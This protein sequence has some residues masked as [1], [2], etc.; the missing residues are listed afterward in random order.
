MTI[1][2]GLVALIVGAAFLVLLV[3]VDGSVASTERARRADNALVEANRVERLVIDLETG[4][5]GFVLTGDERFLEPWR[6]AQELLP[7]VTA[8]LER[9]TVDSPGEAGALQLTEDVTSY[10]EDYSIPLVEAA[11]RHEPTAASVAATLEGKRRVD[12]LRGAVDRLLATEQADLETN[13]GHTDASIRRAIAIAAGGL[14]GSILLIVFFGIYLTRAIVAPIRRAAVMA[15]R[16]AG[17]DLGS[18]MMA[19]GPAEIG[20]LESSFNVMADSLQRDRDELS[21]LAEEQAA[22]RRVA[23]LVASAAPAAELFAAVSEEVGRLLPVDITH[24]TRYGSDG[25]AT[26]VAGWDRSG[27]QVP[28]GARHPL[29]G[30]NLSTIILE[31]RSPARIDVGA[32]SGAMAAAAKAVGARSG[33]GT[34]IVVAGRLWGV[35][36]AASTSEEPLPED[37]EAR[38][39]GFTDLVATAIANAESRTELAASRARVVEAADASRRRIERDL[40]DGA[41]QRLISLGLDLRAAESEVPAELPELRAQLSRA[42]GGLTEVLEDVQEISRGI[43]PAILSKGGLGPAIRTLARRCPVRVELDLRAGGRLPERIEAAAYYVI[44]EALT[45][46]A[47]H[48]QA[49][50]VHVTVQAEGSA[51]EISIRDDGIGGAEPGRGS[52]LIGLMDRVEAFG[53]T[54]EIMSPAR[55][56]TSLLVTLPIDGS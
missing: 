50:V 42:A 32:S 45:N 2:S 4:Q 7:G 30:T 16:L 54:I 20:A 29:E 37:T 5:R 27:R 13:R 9:S 41:Q 1:A 33:I 36:V 56:G 46:A 25:T 24:M 38:L 52:G 15:D 39:A 53:G 21:R 11:R 31:T 55:A 49:S 8:G 14:G 40:H 17:G 44:S 3:A 23:T 43:H 48:A 47:K 19:S 35:M 10:I 34:P 51:V 28:V 22:L 18:R 26:V 12:E 6:A